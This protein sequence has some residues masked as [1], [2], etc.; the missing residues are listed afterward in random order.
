[1]KRTTPKTVGELM[2]QLFKSPNIAAKIAEGS[3]P[4]IWRR[5]VGPVVAEQTRQVRLVRGVLFV[6]IT[7]AIMRN[8]LMMRRDALV[9]AINKEA[10][11]DIVVQ[12]IVQ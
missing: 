8:E 9:R 7:S 11:I 2:E 1:M 4:D 10:G 3:L 12:L 5:V 6:H